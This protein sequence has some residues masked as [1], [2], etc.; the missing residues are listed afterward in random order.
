ME[1][2]MEG[3][4]FDGAVEWLRPFI[5]T[6]CWDYC[7][8]W[9]LGDD[10]SRFV[11]WIGCCCS[12]GG[13]EN[14]NVK[15]QIT[16][17]PLCRDTH[18]QH[19]MRT[20]ACEALALLP[21]SM[22]LYSGL[23]GEVVISAQPRWICAS[24]SDTSNDSIG[25]QVLIPV[26]GGL[27]EL[28]VAKHIPKDQKIIDLITTKCDLSL[29]QGAM[30][31]CSYTSLTLNEN[32]L[33]QLSEEYLQHWPLTLHLL[34]SNPK[35]QVLPPVTQSSSYPSAEGS[36]SSSNPSNDCPLF[37]L[38][39]D[40]INLHGSVKQSIGQSSGSKKNKQNESSLKRQADLVSHCGNMI[41]NGEGNVIKKPDRRFH[42]KNL[43][44]E[45]KRRNRIK[46]GLFTLRSLVPKITKMD[47][48]SI[49]GDAIE[50]IQE[51]QTEVEQLQDVLREVEE[52]DYKKN[53]AELKIATS[54][55]IR[56]GSTVCLPPTEQNHGSSSFVEQ[57]QTE[58]KKDIQ[59]QKLRECLIDLAKNRL[60][61]QTVDRVFCI[62]SR[63]RSV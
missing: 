14:A 23:H 11:E 25:T 17:T 13:C 37:D 52:E 8:V 24:D 15:E 34:S 62:D 7:V 57:K 61:H 38:N 40:Y 16:F 43:V 26:A 42:S 30:S 33:D 19:P 9:K 49:L 47:R 45:R 60:E 53:I 3:L 1:K 35:I 20:K 6:K 4:E 59:P 31:A 41:E 27:I 29:D 55:R 58:A 18:F 54:D 12:G 63:K 32:H 44:T 56:Y 2:T 51:L 46:D 21:S 28:F 50:Y 36:S 10:P 48:A 5:E 39:S 22:P